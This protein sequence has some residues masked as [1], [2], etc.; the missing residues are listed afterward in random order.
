[1]ELILPLL[2]NP[3]SSTLTSIL[4]SCCGLRQLPT[5]PPPLLETFGSE[6]KRSSLSSFFALE[7]LP[8]GTME[9][10]RRQLL[11]LPRR[12]AFPFPRPLPPLVVSSVIVGCGDGGGEL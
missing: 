3:K 6:E 11:K 5:P 4:L 10:C 1:M 12:G 8:D 2:T 9:L 7:V